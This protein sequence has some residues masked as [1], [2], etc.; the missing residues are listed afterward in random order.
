MVTSLEIRGLVAK[1]PDLPDF[2]KYPHGT[3]SRYVSGCRCDE[4]RNATAAYWRKQA[5]RARDI[6]ADYEAP[7]G[8]PASQVWTRPD[9]TKKVRVY[10]RACPGIPGTPCPHSSHLRKDSTG[11]ICARCRRKLAWNGLVPTD[12]V[13]AHLRKLSDKGV[14]YKQVADAADVGRTMVHL[15]MVGKRTMMRAQNEKR[16]LEVD[17]GAIAD[18]G[19]VDARPVWTMIRKLVRKHGYTKVAI[20]RKLGQKGQGLQLGKRRMTAKNAQK[21]EKLFRDAEEVPNR[22]LRRT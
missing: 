5:K 4:C 9:G 11:G 22:L 18:K 3:K 21:I 6:A 17:E 16:I 14:G 2:S 15:I 19:L 12:K 10:A 20:A 1:P 13:L 7:S 8:G